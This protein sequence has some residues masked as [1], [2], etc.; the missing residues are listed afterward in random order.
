MASKG[1]PAC[2][3]Y[4]GIVGESACEHDN[5]LLDFFVRVYIISL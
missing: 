1:E 5:P 3:L 4:A 2:P